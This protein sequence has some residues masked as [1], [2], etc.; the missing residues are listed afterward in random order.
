MS[1]SRRRLGVLGGTFDPIHVGH[2]D[3]ADAARTALALDEILF[4]P[5]HDPP[6]RALDPHASPFHRFAL[7]A[8]AI[9]GRDGFRVSDMELRRTGASF[10]ATTL[11]ELQRDGWSPLQI[12]FIIGADAFADIATWYAYPAVLDACH[13]AVVARQGVTL[14]GALAHAPAVAAR[15]RP[16]T[17]ALAD[18]GRT[19]VFPI[20]ASTSAV[21]SSEIRARLAEEQSIRG[22]VPPA[23][24]RHI[25]TH[26]LYRA[27][28]GSHLRRP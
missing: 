18:M 13:F 19:G 17:Q 2:L 12:F 8:L 25:Y 4:V 28:A 9:E 6:H 1:A 20:D 3:A 22:M 15:V 11:D 10:T 7:A 21:S 26:E 24:E 16:L 23:V 14:D 27:P 5:A